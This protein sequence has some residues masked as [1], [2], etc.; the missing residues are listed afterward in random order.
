MS[1]PSGYREILQEWIRNRPRNGYGEAKNM[2]GSIGI[3]SVMMSQILNGDREMSLEQAEKAARYMGCTADE[4]RFFLLLVTR[5]RAGTASLK[6]LLDDAIDERKRNFQN[7][8][9]FLR[10]KAELPEEAKAEFYSSWTYAAIHLL[11][12]MPAFQTARAISDRLG[13]D[14]EVTDARLRFL[15][16]YGLCEKDGDTYKQSSSS[17]YLPRGP[18][19]R[20]FHT[21]RRLL[22]LE[23]YDRSMKD[24]YF[25]GF[26]AI[27]SDAFQ[28]FR[29][30]LSRAIQTHSEEAAASTAEDLF[31]VNVDAF[32]V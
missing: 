2:A 11:T 17:M 22:A 16:K 28:K 21:Q 24:F 12:E 25:S 14:E 30:D 29:E 32:R 31:C 1:T 19:S 20:S 4:T 3:S 10:G 7:W 8:N 5:E 6:R 26:Y 9:K 13:L 15:V 27:S 23:R 18:F